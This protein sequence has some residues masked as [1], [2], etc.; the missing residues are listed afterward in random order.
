MTGYV[1]MWPREVFEAKVDALAFL[2]QPGVYILYSGNTAY[3]VGQGNRLRSRLKR[4]AMNPRSQRYLSWDSFSAFII[5]KQKCRNELEAILIA[6]ANPTANRAKPRLP[7]RR[8]PRDVVSVV[9]NIHARY[10]PKAT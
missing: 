2:D 1:R 4:R 5:P 9:R 6:A 3:Y 7:E 10:Q 8:M